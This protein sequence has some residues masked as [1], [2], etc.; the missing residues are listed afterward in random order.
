MV[1]QSLR[2]VPLKKM[3]YVRDALQPA[4]A[5][6]WHGNQTLIHAAAAGRLARRIT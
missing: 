5:V 6:V 3:P 2:I 4:G 1:E